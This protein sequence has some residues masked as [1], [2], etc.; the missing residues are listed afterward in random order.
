M[1][2]I[3]L[4]LLLS[5][6]CMMALKDFF[7]SRE[8]KVC[9]NA[10][11]DRPVEFQIY[12]LGSNDKV[13]DIKNSLRVLLTP[14]GDTGFQCVVLKI[15]KRSLHKFRLDFG[16][17]PGEVQVKD[18]YLTGTT[19]LPISDFTQFEFT[20]IDSKSLSQNKLTLQS[21]HDN[22]YIVYKP[23]FK[24]R[25]RYQVDWKMFVIIA[26]GVL[27]LIHQLVQYLSVFKMRDQ[28]SRIDIVFLV[29]FFILLFMPMLKIDQSAKSKLENR[30]LA[31]YV[32]LLKKGKVNTDYGKN[33]ERWFSDRC[34]GRYL[35]LKTYKELNY[36]LRKY[37]YFKDAYCFNNGWMCGYNLSLD[38]K[39]FPAIRDGI[40]SLQKFCEQ[41]GIQPYI[42]IPPPKYT[43]IRDEV[44]FKNI[45][46]QDELS[47][48][49]VF[50]E[51]T[52]NI[53]IVYPLEKSL[54][55]HKTDFVYFKTDHHWT[56]SGAYLAY[57]ELI[58]E[59][60]K[61]FPEIPMAEESDFNVFYDHRVRANYDRL[62]VCGRTASLLML[63]AEE[64]LDG[65]KYKYYKHKDESKMIVR[66]MPDMIKFFE[67][68]GAS[69]K[70]VTLLGNSFVENF[71]CFLPYSFNNV[72]QIRI[73]TPHRNHIKLS[74][75]KDSILSYKT[76]I[77]VL[78]LDSYQIDKFAEL[79][80]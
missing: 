31:K 74:H 54:E 28:H 15:P 32:P 42:L 34:Q 57:S 52:T 19:K 3:F 21:L 6:F 61:C 24:L 72:Q 2:R 26:S 58:N 76:D 67:Y 55:K 59:M 44:Y 9:F 38:K 25:G 13:F 51:E 75:Y 77:L 23:S 80:E 63:S 41:Y 11:V 49:K 22:P 29:I 47:R 30:K 7:L 71:S 73:N 40:I 8:I 65:T 70:K 64:A 35:L 46:V 33:F 12:Y 43:H 56:E 62:F 78:L 39:K 4:V 14:K 66:Q 5:C 17:C 68:Q 60:Q 18:F 79:R 10:K 1:K 48:L 36:R 53:P 20:N 16:N 37:Y 50:L 45:T 27:L 69:D